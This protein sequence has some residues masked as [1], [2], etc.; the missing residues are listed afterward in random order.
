MGILLLAA[1]VWGLGESRVR[2]VIISFLEHT[3]QVQRLATDG[4]G[5][6]RWTPAL[7]NAPIIEGESIRTDPNSAAEVELECG[8]ALRLAPSTEL[9]FNRLRLSDD[10]IRMTTVTLDHGEAFFTMQDA[11]SRDFQTRLSGGGVISMPNGGASLRLDV[12]PGQAPS[13]E[14]LGGQVLVRDHGKDSTVRSARRIAFEPGGGIQLFVLAKPDAWQIWSHKRDQAFQR[15]VLA[16]GPKPPVMYA[17]GAAATDMAGSATEPAPPAT[18]EQV[19]G[20][21]QALDK[22]HPDTVAPVAGAIPPV[23]HCAHR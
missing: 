12:L 22:T 7:L 3:V 9:T 10:G 4:H 14:V 1:A 8:S 2:I 11:D 23:P 21:F 20:D 17:A 16:S 5:L 13:I 6:Q 18:P 15:E 19:Q